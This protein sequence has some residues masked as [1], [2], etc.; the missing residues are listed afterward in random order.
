LTAFILIGAVM[1]SI[2][3]GLVAWPIYQAR[4]S[5]GRSALVVLGVL[6]LALPVGAAV[7]YRSISNWDWDPAAIEAASQSGQHSLP[8]MVSQLEDR[9]KK[10]PDDVGGWLMLGRSRLV[11]NDFAAASSAFKRAY[12]VSKGKNV[13]A[14]L[15]YGATLYRIDSTA[16]NGRAG[17]LFE[18]ALKLD[19][20]NPEALWFGG[21]AARNSGRLDVAR[22]RWAAT[23]KSGAE[24]PPEFRAML[25]QQISDLDRQLGRKPDPELA[26]IAAAAVAAAATTPTAMPVAQA[27]GGDGNA[28]AAPPAA[29]AGTPGTVTV[30]VKLGPAV[31]G[32]VPPGALLFVLARDPTQPGPPFAVKRLPGATLPLDIVLT[33]QDAML[34]ARTIKTAKQLLIV[35]RFSVSGMP[36]ASSGDVYGEVPYE[37]ASAKPVDLVIDKLVP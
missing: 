2:A 13:E 23:L 32:K 24:M 9:L 35:A 7:L 25:V 12:E 33:E 37:L 11:M 26:K 3:L 18:E 21:T 19:P 16:I 31:A 29:A 28:R 17:E 36:T 14:V 8:E 30:H 5:E 27:S 6:A 22:E 10:A 15:G 20:A 4:S 1:V 34:P